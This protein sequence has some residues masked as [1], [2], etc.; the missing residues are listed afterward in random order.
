MKFLKEK[1]GQVLV[2]SIIALSVLLV[3]F[4]SLISLLNNSLG[5]NRVVTENYIA[6]YL[7]AEGIEY[8]KNKI[9]TNIL[10][11]GLPWNHQLNDGYYELKFNGNDFSLEPLSS[12]SSASLLKFD[13][14]NKVYNYNNTFPDTPFKRY[15]YIE[16]R[17]PNVRPNEIVVNSVVFWT[18]RGGGKYEVNLEDHFFDKQ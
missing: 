5:L 13:S 7:A 3:G 16:N 18:S 1:S 4:L 8:V 10:N 9:D 12:T 11:P 6:T 17:P 15:I 14:N 2:E